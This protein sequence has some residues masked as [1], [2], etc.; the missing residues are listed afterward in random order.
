[1][2]GTRDVAG[3][4]YAAAVLEIARQERNLDSWVEAVE[5]LEALTSQPAFVAGLQGDGM[6]D[7]RF[8][9]IVRRVVPGVT[10]VQL[11]LF[12]LLRRKARLGLGPDIASFFRELVDEERGIARA[13][14]TSAVALEPDRRAALERRLAEQTGR[15]VTVETQVDPSILGGL[16]VRIGD[17]LVDGSTRAR[18]RALRAQLERP[19][20]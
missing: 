9:A 18:L 7:E 16:I 19:A 12:R 14:V 8:Q 20:L 11:N 13:L 4:R 10:P 17:R 5:G 3:R 1:M 6:T 2:A 15:Q